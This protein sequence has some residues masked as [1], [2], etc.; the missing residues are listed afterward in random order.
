[1]G[2][3][4]QRAV[5]EVASRTP[6]HFAGAWGGGGEIVEGEDV[7]G[8]GGEDLNG[9]HGWL[10]GYNSEAELVECGPS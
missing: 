8:A 6:L 10:S 3:C 5:N 9:L 2:H 7:G 4:G 1:M